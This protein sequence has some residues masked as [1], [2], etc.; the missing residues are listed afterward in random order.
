MTEDTVT[1]LRSELAG[2]SGSAR[3]APLSRLAQA[4][5][6][7]YWRAGPGRPEALPILNDAIAAWQ[8]CLGYLREGDSVRGQVAAQL[9]WLLGARYGTHTEDERDREAGMRVLTEALDSPHLS[10][11][12]REMSRLQLGQLC[13]GRVTKVLQ[14]PGTGMQLLSGGLAPDIRADVDRAV[15]CFRQVLAEGP[16]SDDLRSAAG[17]LLS[18]AEIMQTMVSGTGDAGIDLQ[19]MMAAMAKLQDLQDRFGKISGAGQGRRGTA[20]FLSFADMQSIMNVAPIDRPVAVVEQA[21]PSSE[22][23]LPEPPVVPEPAGGAGLRSSLHEKLSG[24]DPDQP[25]WARA[26]DLLLPDAPGLPIDV[27]DELVAL[28]TMVV[29]AED[30]DNAAA[31]V[32][33]FVLAVT[34]NLRDR[35]DD[36]GD[37]ADAVAGAECLLAAVR[38]LP[39]GH[40]GATTMLL[41]L[42][43][44]LDEER[45]FGGPLE[46]VAGEFAD[47]VDAVIAAGVTDAADLAALHALRCLCRAAE[48]VAELRR[49]AVPPDYP[50]RNALKAAG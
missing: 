27:V 33:R 19:G 4:L 14:T 24:P 40:P 39:T 49:A 3:V 1:T 12:L 7:R 50:W 10:K 5:A 20:S 38:D 36:D 28:A 22:P 44:F 32:D 37:R 41:C 35:L 26:A 23:A 42:G 9:G 2:L 17:S 11:V 43:A 48:A 8:E 15:G 21:E 34:L 25:V 30:G 18:A 13:L 45:P 6:E 16:S 29:E 47:R 31:A 46:V